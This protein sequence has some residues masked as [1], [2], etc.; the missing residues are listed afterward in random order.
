[1]HHAHTRTKKL[2]KPRLLRLGEN[3]E[4]ARENKH[5]YFYISSTKKRK[6]HKKEKN[7]QKR[8]MHKKEKNS[9]KKKN[10]K[11]G[12]QIMRKKGLEGRAGDQFEV[13]N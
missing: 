6:M 8:K 3:N 1:M 9:P 2:A 12:G 5:F 13:G 10:A 7:S 4:K 11:K